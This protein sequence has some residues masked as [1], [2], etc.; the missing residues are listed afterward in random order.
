MYGTK[1]RAFR[2]LRG[3]SQEYVA[4]QLGINQNSYS[5]IET[6][7]QK[8]ID[9]DTLKKIAEVLGVTVADITS[10]EPI[11]IQNQ[12][13]NQGTQGI[14][15]IEHFYTDQKDL[16]QQLLDTK[17]KEIERLTKQNEKLMNMLEK[18]K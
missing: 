16:Y 17:D 15:H 7:Q 4:N 12:A 13:S 14:G 8:K 11:I 9:I 2:T 3:L 10:N 1:I 5:R 18:K 6:N